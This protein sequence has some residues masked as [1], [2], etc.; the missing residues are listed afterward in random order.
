MTITEQRPSELMAFPSGEIWL[1][2]RTCSGPKAVFWPSHCKR[3]SSE[4][5]RGKRRQCSTSL[6]VFYFSSCITWC[7]E[8]FTA[9]GLRG[10]TT[11]CGLGWGGQGW[12]FRFGFLPAISH[13]YQFS[14]Q[15]SGLALHLGFGKT[16]NSVRKVGLKH[17][18]A[19]I[20]P[21]WVLKPSLADG[22]TLI[23]KQPQSTEAD[24]L[25]C[26][27]DQKQWGCFRLPRSPP[28]A[29]LQLTEVHSTQPP[30]PNQASATDI[31]APC[32]CLFPQSGKIC[33]QGLNSVW[34]E[35]CFISEPEIS[36]K[37]EHELS[38]RRELFVFFSQ[39][40]SDI[41]FLSAN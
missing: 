1:L 36:D 27:S 32:N 20:S 12:D 15:P 9:S 29:S 3:C 28:T 31:S 16:K 34:K 26:L 33:C 11:L 38:E 21:S 30:K 17:L 7:I 5:K 23:H 13:S 24:H 4:S 35:C 40:C 19:S 2:E 37:T 10:S 41:A 8:Y 25:D 18:K 22:W 39:T 14:H 6:C